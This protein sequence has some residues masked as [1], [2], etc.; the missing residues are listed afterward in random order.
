MD[1]LLN[2]SSLVVLYSHLITLFSEFII[3]HLLDELVLVIHTLTELLFLH[4]TS[5]GIHA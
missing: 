2:L 5:S 1:V 3:L 4:E